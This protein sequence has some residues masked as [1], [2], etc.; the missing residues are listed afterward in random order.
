MAAKLQKLRGTAQLAFS[1]ASGLS[2]SVEKMH[3]TIARRPLPWSPPPDKPT[4]AHGL[5]ASSVYSLV[6]N[7]IDA[8]AKG[9]DLAFHVLPGHQT[10]QP[11]TD[12]E[13]RM[14]AALNG[15][16][17]DHLESTNNPLSIPMRLFQDGLP[18]KTSSSGLAAAYP[19][20]SPHVTV[21]VHGLCVSELCW[22]R[23]NKPDIGSQL[24][25]Q[26][27]MTPV[28]LRY[29]TGRHISTN[30]REFSTLLQELCTH[31]PVPVESLSLI[32]HSMGGL[33]IRSACWYANE[34]NRSWIRFMRRVISLGTPHHGSPVEK[35]GH[36]FDLAMRGIQY[37]EPLAF[38]RKRS[39]GIKDLR[40]GNLLDQDWLDQ[41]EDESLVDR[42]SAAPLLT[43]VD[44][45]F[46][47]ASLGRHVR[48]PKGMLL[49]DLLV[50]T[51]SATGNHDDERMRLEI[52]PENCRVFHE[53]SHL[54]LLSDAKVHAQ[55]IEW[56]S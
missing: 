51:K 34:E 31:W 44:Y 19:D 23:E 30:G 12:R 49:G 41:E 2:N 21:L 9:V 47:A 22:S 7:A 39:A 16:C 10:V 29:N 35:V 43:G 26:L 4:R 25:E 14:S 6:H 8:C 17:G 11:G 5:V 53:Q 24:H 37:V 46:A 28:Y 36:L 13:T 38:G 1:A 33:V 48:D 32:G 20:A 15:V 18:V 42:R 27:G 3:E 52:S 56:C 50:S 55:I 54:G 40:Y 45:Y